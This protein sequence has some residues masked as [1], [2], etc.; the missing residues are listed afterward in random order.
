MHSDLPTSSLVTCVTGT[1][2]SPQLPQDKDTI[3]YNDELVIPYY[4]RDSLKRA[5]HHLGPDNVFVSI[6]EGHSTNTTAELLQELDADLALMVAS[7][8]ILTG[9]ETV[10][11]PDYL[12]G[13]KVDF[14]NDISINPKTLVELL[15]TNNG[16]YNMACSLDL[17][18]FGHHSN[19][20][21][22]IQYVGSPRP[23]SKTRQLNTN[24]PAPVFSC[25]NGIVV[26][27]EASINRLPDGEE[28]VSVVKTLK[29]SAAALN[30]CVEKCVASQS[31]SAE[32]PKRQKSDDDSDV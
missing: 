9:D 19:T 21:R 18:H 6:V 3:I 5:I 12:G 2:S 15:E 13:Y 32:L 22:H 1:P 11:S 8:R 30:K 29:E 4:W 26:F 23:T 14:S 27:T 28:L 20:A 17:S 10:A 25:R 24:S 7:W 16:N 31:F